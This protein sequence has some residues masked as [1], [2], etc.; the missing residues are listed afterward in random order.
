MNKRSRFKGLKQ[1]ALAVSGCCLVI[2]AEAAKL[3]AG[4]DWDLNFDNSVMYNAGWRAQDINPLIGNHI[5]F[6]QGDYK[7]AKKGDM[8]TDRIQDLIEFQ[9]IYQGQMGFRMSASVWKDFA[10]NNKAEQNPALTPVIGNAYE[11]G[12][13]N[14]VVH[15]EYVQGGEMLDYFVFLNKDIGDT[16]MQLKA[17]RLTQYW[18]N[19]FFFGF[20]NIGYSQS[21]IDFQKGFAQPGTEVKELFLPRRQGG[22]PEFCVNGGSVKHSAYGRRT[23][24]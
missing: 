10:Y 3:D 20:T 19:A 22:C 8:V 11:N 5:A 14:G 24:L 12:T 18:G 17:G 15:K 9:G 7:F 13:Y 2:G 21:P 6:A 1:I 4:S 16:P 23:G